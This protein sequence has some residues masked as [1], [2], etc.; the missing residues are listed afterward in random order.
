MEWGR[1]LFPRNKAK[2]ELQRLP[3]SHLPRFL[4]AQ[5]LGAPEEAGAREHP[6]ARGHGE[7][8]EEQVAGVLNRK[9]ET[10]PR[11]LHGLAGQRVRERASRTF[12]VSDIQYLV[13]T[14]LP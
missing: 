11:C 6:K 12:T 14:N 2:P 3:D 4:D 1:G 5:H 13:V 8:D 7:H 10:R 9:P